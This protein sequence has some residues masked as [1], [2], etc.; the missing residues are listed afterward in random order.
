LTRGIKEGNCIIEDF[1]Q[2]SLFDLSKTR[3]SDRDF[4]FG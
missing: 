2:K 3:V 1:Y 4:F